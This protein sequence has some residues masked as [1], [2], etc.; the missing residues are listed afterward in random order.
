MQIVKATWD[1][2]RGH[3]GAYHLGCNM[4]S[5]LSYYPSMGFLGRYANRRNEILLKGDNYESV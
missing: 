3:S 2:F 5:C 1:I 4:Q